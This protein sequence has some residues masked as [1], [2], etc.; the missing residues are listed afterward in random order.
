MAHTPKFYE[1]YNDEKCTQCT[2]KGIV[3]FFEPQ[4]NWTEER[5]D[6]LTAYSLRN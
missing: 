5:I 3:E 4:E 1:N 2:I 6:Q